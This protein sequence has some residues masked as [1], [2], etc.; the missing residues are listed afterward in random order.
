VSGDLLNE[1]SKGCDMEHT[2]LWTMLELIKM[3][4]TNRWSDTSFSALLELLTKVLP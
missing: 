2:V 3:K 4:A 1:E